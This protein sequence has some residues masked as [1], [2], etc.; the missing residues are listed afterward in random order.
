MKRR[1]KLRWYDPIIDLPLVVVFM[2]LLLVLNIWAGLGYIVELI[3][4]DKG[5]G[6]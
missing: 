2:I 4:P 1:M 3:K 5:G 6:L